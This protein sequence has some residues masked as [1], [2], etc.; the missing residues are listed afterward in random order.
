LI[1]CYLTSNE[2]GDVVVVI[3]W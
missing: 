1:D 3:V 2:Q